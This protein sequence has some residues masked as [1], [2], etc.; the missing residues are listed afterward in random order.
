MESR[1]KKISIYMM[2]IGLFTLPLLSKAQNADTA[3]ADSIQE[4]PGQ[5]RTDKILK[6]YSVTLHVGATTPYTDV[7][8]LDFS[9]MFKDKSDIQ[10]AVGASVTRMFGGVFGLQADYTFGNLV[11]VSEL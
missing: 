8:S 11:G 5:I 4:I 3:P 7:R 2:M 1:I 10:W 6:N 9:R